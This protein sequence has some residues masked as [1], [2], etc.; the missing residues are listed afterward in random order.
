MYCARL[1]TSLLA[2]AAVT[3]FGI[4][5]ASAADYSQPLPC[6]DAAEIAS[7]RAPYGAIPCYVA[8]RKV[9]EFSGWYLRGDIGMS[10]QQAKL[11]HPS[12]DTSPYTHQDDGF[13]SAPIFGIGL[14][15][16]YN[17]WLRFDVT[18]EYRGSASYHGYGTYPGGSDEYRARKKEWVGLVNGY[19]DL[20]TWYKLTPFVGAGVG[21]AYNTVDSFLDINTPTGG[22]YSAQGA[23]KFNFAWALHAGVAYKVT[24][25]FT[26]QLAYRYL[27]LG[28][29]E[30]GNGVSYDGSNAN[31]RPF[32]FNNLVSHDIMLGLRFNLDA[33][34]SYAPAPTY[35]APPPPLRSKG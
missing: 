28:S 35:Y 15:Y 7:G 30:T 4:G 29:A 33:G 26:V 17:D 24:P 19:V 12:F 31:G 21:F 34:D 18:G 5:A 23:S 14:G 1:K 11:Y 32:Q 22:A 10:N 8:P 13:D 9:E 20:G 2:V 27:D 6:Y 16:Y 25:G 3:A